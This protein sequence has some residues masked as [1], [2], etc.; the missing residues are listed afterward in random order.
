MRKRGKS[1]L[2]GKTFLQLRKIYI[3]IIWKFH[4]DLT[5]KRYSCN[6]ILSSHLAYWLLYTLGKT[7]SQYFTASRRIL[8]CV[9][10]P[11]V[12]LR[13]YCLRRK[14]T[15]VKCYKVITFLMHQIEETSCN[16]A[17]CFQSTK[18]WK[19]DIIFAF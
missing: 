16:Y 9:L 19:S 6:A 17:D 1:I 13:V 11:L 12:S 14:C 8:A 18:R 4:R 3:Y 10:L 5:F 2:Y 15:V 7:R